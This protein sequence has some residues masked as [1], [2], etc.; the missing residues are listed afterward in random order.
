MLLFQRLRRLW[1]F[2]VGGVGLVFWLWVLFFLLKSSCTEKYSLG[3]Q[4]HEVFIRQVML[5]NSHL[6]KI[7]KHHKRFILSFLIQDISRT[8]TAEF[9]KGLETEK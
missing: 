3:E 8:L 4:N 5:S 7:K 1:A 9:K 2:G 6:T